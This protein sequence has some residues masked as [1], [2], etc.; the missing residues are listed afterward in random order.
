M[1]RGQCDP[2]AVG[3]LEFYSDPKLQVLNKNFLIVF[4]RF[5]LNELW[6][7]QKLKSSDNTLELLPSWM[8][9]GFIILVNI[10]VRRNLHNPNFY[11]IPQQWRVSWGG[12]HSRRGWKDRGWKEGILNYFYNIRDIWYRETSTALSPRDTWSSGQSLSH[13]ITSV[14]R[15]EGHPGTVGNITLKLRVQL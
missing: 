8:F 2:A 13:L 10:S 5:R 3:Q 12:G 9:K 1:H 14:M 15:Q 11:L 7:L 4:D 6:K